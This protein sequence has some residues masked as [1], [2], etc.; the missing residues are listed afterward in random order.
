MTG[1]RVSSPVPRDLRFEGCVLS[2]VGP[3]ADANSVLI[4][5]SAWQLFVRGLLNTFPFLLQRQA[6]DDSIWSSHWWKEQ[7][8]GEW[9]ETIPGPQAGLSYSEAWQFRISPRR[10]SQKYKTNQ[11][12]AKLSAANPLNVDEHWAIYDERFEKRPRNSYK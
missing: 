3:A 8:E 5:V 6:K 2:A 7:R 4:Q 12:R 11:F 10:N 9:S 1:W